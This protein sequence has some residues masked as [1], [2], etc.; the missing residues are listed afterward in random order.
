MNEGIKMSESQK[1][2]EQ[3]AQRLYTLYNQDGV[4]PLNFIPYGVQL[5]KDGWS[6]SVTVTARK[7]RSKK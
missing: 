1:R 5:E 3:E 6:Y 4:T 7:R 2:Q